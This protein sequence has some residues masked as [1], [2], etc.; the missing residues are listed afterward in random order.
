MYKSPHLAHHEEKIRLLLDDIRW[1]DELTMLEIDS[2]E[3]EDRKDVVDVIIRLLFGLMIERKGRAR[4]ADRRVAV[5]TALAGCT[6]DELG[7]LLI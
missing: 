4:G 5:L 6:D 2:V 3:Q 7:Y 1:R